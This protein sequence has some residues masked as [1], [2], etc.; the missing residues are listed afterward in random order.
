MSNNK[1][2]KIFSGKPKGE[3]PPNESVSPPSNFIRS[4][5]DE[6]MRNDKWDGRVMTRFPPEPNGYLHIGHAKSICLNFGLAQDYKGLCNLRFDDTD[7][8]KE[9]IEYVDSIKKDVRWLGF[10]WQD[11]EYYA[12]D[13]F[14]KLFDHAVALIKTGK[15][16]IDSLSPEKIR[17]Y[18]GTLTEA[19]KESPDRSRTIE[20]NLDLFERMRSG[21]FEEGTYVLRAKIDMAAPNL[22]MRDPT[23]YR[24]KHVHHYRTGDRW[25]IYPMYDF[26]HCL[27]DSIEGITHSICTLEFENNRELYDWVLD[28][29]QVYHPQQIEFARLNLSYTVLSKRKLIELAE[30]GYVEGW[31]D[32]RMP[33]ISGMRRRGYT[34]A[35]IRNF[36]D[37][38]G[39][40]K[41]NSLVDRA[42]LEYGVREDLNKSAARVMAVLRP[43]KLIIDDYPEDRVEE[44][45]AENNPEDPS[46]GKRSLPF[47]KVLYVEKDDFREE[48]PRKWFRL[49]PGREVRLKHAYYVTC[50]DVAK[51]DSTGEVIELHCT[52]DPE[53]RGGWSTDGRKVKGTLHWVSAKHALDAEVRL[54]DHLFLKRNPNEV[55]EGKDFKDY[56]NPDSLEVLKG[57]KVEPSLANA[58]PGSRYQFLRLGYYCVDTKDSADGKPVFNRTAT[59][60][61]TW[62][63]I[64][65]AQKS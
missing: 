52:Y 61:D 46:M 9:S 11:R 15:A 56:I 47:S 55:E 63:K 53:T 29:L 60:R 14:E 10:D 5:I 17:Q 31:D 7:P 57:C 8:S 49:A 19:G 34:P 16:Y 38:I 45:E 62:A 26:T 2:E 64:E 50:T 37:R 39:V 13:Y 65:K 54:Y 43:L 40:A 32:P 23:L 20:E 33:T 28:Q 1:G 21:E 24:I 22:L 42:L 6:D 58:R 30:G 35:S 51:D 36:C 59:L 3:N 25:C 18:R 27:S 44:L 48:A 41:S 4:I 12:S